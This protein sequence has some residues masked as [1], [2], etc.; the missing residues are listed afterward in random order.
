MK[1]PIMEKPVV[2][3]SHA[4]AD[5]AQLVALK[6]LLDKKAAGALDFFLS[7]DGQSIKLGR[8]WVARLTDALKDTKLMFV[9]LS[10]KSSDSKWIH[11]EAGHAYSQGVR[12]VP[13]CMPG[14]SLDRIAQP[15]SLL[16]GFNL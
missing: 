10:S 3:L 8:N 5:K 4:S 13:V 11:F 16:Q 6:T 9:F 1:K 2:F 7:S 12:V 14:M 15:I